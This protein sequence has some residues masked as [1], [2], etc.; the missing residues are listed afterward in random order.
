MKYITS[1]RNGL[2]VV[3][4]TL[5]FFFVGL[6]CQAQN[7]TNEMIEWF[8][9]KGV[10]L[11]ADFAHPNPTNNYLRHNIISESSSCIAVEIIY[12]GIFTEYSCWYNVYINTSED[13]TPYFS[14]VVC[15][16]EGCMFA[17]CF[18]N[19][20]YEDY[21]LHYFDYTSLYGESSFYDLSTEKKAAFA[22]TYEFLKR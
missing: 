18:Q 5:A 22:L 9:N 8:K 19:W 13:N 2:K 11:L 21:P 6:N 17:Y 7:T 16:K 4:M 20:E 12:N 10:E 15:T 1:K 14:S 3:V